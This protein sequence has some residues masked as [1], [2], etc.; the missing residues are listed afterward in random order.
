MWFPMRTVGLDFLETAGK[1]YRMECALQASR[2]EVW[3]AFVDPSTW[4]EWFPGVSSASYPG[5]T[6]P[7]GVG[8]ARAATVSGTRV[9]WILAADR[10]LLMWLAGPLLHRQLQRLFDRAIRNLDTYLG[11]TKTAA[12]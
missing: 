4:S 12:R 8:T 9:R 1:T 10:R 2:R 11:E 3:N 7:Y 5:Q 6:P